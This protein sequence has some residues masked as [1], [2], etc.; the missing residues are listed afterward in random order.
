M[1]ARTS[2]GLVALIFLISVGARADE[3]GVSHWV[4]EKSRKVFITPRFLVKAHLTHVGA[5][6][7]YWDWLSV[8]VNAATV[9]EEIL[10]D[11]RAR[12]PGYA[13]NGVVSEHE[14]NMRVSIPVAGIALELPT[15]TGG[16]GP[17]AAH[18][19]GI[20]RAAAAAVRAQLEAGHG[21]VV[22]GS[23]A[24]YVPTAEV[25][26]KVELGSDTCAALGSAGDSV[27]K[28]LQGYVGIAGLV[29]TRIQ[30]HHES[31]RES[32]MSS[33][34]AGCASLE[35]GR[36]DSM[37]QLLARGIALR[38]DAPGPVGMTWRESTPRIVQPLRLDYQ[39]QIGGR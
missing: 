17:W 7:Q 28:A 26:E 29:K 14:G 30:F 32:L 6:D 8:E 2:A 1:Q 24:S 35:P 21:L 19:F 23:I 3:P 13:L 9:S 25:L 36:V 4:N 27:Y 37:K 38:D 34:F 16:S 31:T 18:A 11:L 33:V 22:E 39:F 10:R 5:D 15:G 12:Y 20:S